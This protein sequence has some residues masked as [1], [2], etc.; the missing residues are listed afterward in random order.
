[1]ESSVQS[2]EKTTLTGTTQT[3][4]RIV[5]MIVAMMVM[6]VAMMVLIVAMMVLIVAMMVMVMIMMMMMV[7]TKID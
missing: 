2:R 6:I 7:E 4:R 1:M 3:Y 5:V